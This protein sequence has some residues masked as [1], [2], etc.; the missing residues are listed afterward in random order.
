MRLNFTRHLSDTRRF[1]LRSCLFAIASSL[2][3]AS[4]ATATPRACSLLKPKAIQNKLR[5]KQPPEAKP[6]VNEPQI[7]TGA[8]GAQMVGTTC[9]YE[10]NLYPHAYLV[11]F[12]LSSKT[13]AQAEYKAQLDQIGSSGYNRRRVKGPWS[14][15]VQ[16]N[17]FMVVARLGRR[18]VNF[19]FVQHAD[20]PRGYPPRAARDLTEKIA[21]ALQAS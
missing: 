2:V 1:A 10:R 6:G 14:K 20:K 4:T 8:S 17:K 12:T 3:L 11:L 21:R 7:S 5:L 19:Q 15:A 16:F 18:I 9:S 13:E